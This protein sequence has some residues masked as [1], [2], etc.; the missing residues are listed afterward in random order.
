MTTQELKRLGFDLSSKPRGEGYCD[1][2]CSKC[3]AMVINGKPCHE[4][5]CPNE[6]RT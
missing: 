6:K 2:K 4:R 3:N 1:V 5:G